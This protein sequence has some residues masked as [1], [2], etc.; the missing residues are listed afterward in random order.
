MGG[1]LVGE[2]GGGL[3]GEGEVRLLVGVVTGAGVVCRGGGD[4]GVVSAGG[5]V[6]GDGWGSPL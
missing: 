3:V 1:G 5:V 2:G 6:F 4:G